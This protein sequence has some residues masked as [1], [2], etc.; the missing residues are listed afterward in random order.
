MTS[1]DSQRPN[2]IDEL[3]EHLLALTD[4][5]PIAP[6]P[7]SG[8]DGEDHVSVVIDESRRTGISRIVYSGYK[9]L[10]DYEIPLQ[11]MNILTGINNAGKSTALSA[12]RILATA[13]AIA[14]RKKPELL[15][16]PSGYQSGYLVPTTNLEISL[17]NVHTDLCDRDSSVTFSYFNG[18]ELVLWF[19]AD[20]GCTLFVGPNSEVAPRTPSAFKRAFDTRIIQVPVLG[21]LE[22]GESLLKKETVQAGATTHKA[23][24]HFRNFWHYFPDNFDRFAAL[25][26]DTWPGMTISPPELHVELGGARL[27]MFCQENRRTRELYWSGFGFQIWCQLLTHVCRAAPND[28]LVIDEPETYLHPMIQ[29]RLLRILRGTGAQI[30]L[31]THSASIVMA[32]DDNDVIVVDK[33]SRIASRQNKRAAALAAQ[34]GLN[35]TPN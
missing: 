35:I 20:G 4:S 6:E 18:G 23:C 17:E 32:A 30:V 25:L 34:L 3:L 16:T 21:P 1:S 27:H 14:S 11:H 13:I 2:A 8:D 5:T 24:R 10:G 26:A 15:W 22:Y 12:L 31:A 33:E 19:P 9:A 28:L 7:P 29:R